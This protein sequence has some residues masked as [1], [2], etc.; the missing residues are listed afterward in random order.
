MVLPVA[1]D[2]WREQA[3]CRGKPTGLWF[4]D[5]AL[6]RAIALQVCRSCPVQSE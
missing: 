2:G 6:E 3:A 5:D 1:R 4:S